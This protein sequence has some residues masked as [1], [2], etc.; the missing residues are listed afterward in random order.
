MRKLHQTLFLQALFLPALCF[1]Q[2]A[3]V[4]ETV[5]QKGHSRYVS[6]IAYSPDGKY[7]ASGSLDNTI[8]LWNAASNKI[9]R[10]F[11]SHTG[12]IRHVEFNRLGNQILS[13]AS[14]NK[15]IVHDI[16]NGKIIASV[17]QKKGRLFRACFSPDGSKILTDDEAND[18]SVWN[19]NTGRLIGKYSR[20]YSAK[21]EPN[22]F[23][24]DGNFLLI[25]N[26]RETAS[27]VSLE[28]GD[29]VRNFAIDK[30]FSF[31]ISGN[32][33]YVVIGSTKNKVKVFDLESGK[34][35]FENDIRKERG[36]DGCRAFISIGPKNK[37]I[38]VASAEAA[39]VFD[40]R[41]GKT[42]QY[43]ISKKSSIEGVGM[44]PNAQQ[45]YITDDDDVTIYSIASGKKLLDIDFN[46][47]ECNV[48]IPPNGKTMLTTHSN[49]R[50]ALWDIPK[51]KIVKVY[52]G[53]QNH[54]K[55]DGMKFKEG[56]WFHSS[57]IRY[58]RA[59]SKIAITSDGK[60]L[61]KGNVDTV[62]QM[63]NLETGRVERTFLGHSQRVLSIDISKDEK[64]LLTSSADRT[65]K[66][67]DIASGKLIK[68]IGRHGE[69]VFDAKF[70]NNNKLIASASWDGNLITWDVKTGDVVN[71]VDL[72][73]TSPY[74]VSFTPNDLYLVV[75]NLSKELNFY[76]TD[77][78]KEFRKLI[79]HS[80]I[81]SEV[82][83]STDNNRL[84]SASFDGKLKVW[85][86]LSGML[87]NK[88]EGHQSRVYSVA[89]HPGGKLIASG[90]NDRSIQLWD[91]NT[92][93]LKTV[94]PGHSG[95]VTSIKFDNNGKRLVSCSIEG[96]IKVWD[97]TSN[98]ELY[99][100]IPID[101]N[102]WLAKTPGGYFDGTPDALKHIN[103]VS[104][105]ETIPVGS[106]F[107]K[108]YSPNLIRRINNGEDFRAQGNI[109]SLMN[110]VPVIE[111]KIQGN[112]NLISENTDSIDWYSENATLNIQVTDQGG[113][114]DEI[115]IYNNNKLIQ[116]IAY[117]DNSK[118]AGRKQNENL[119]LA[120][121]PG[122]N[123]I[124]VIAL[125][126]ERTE[127]E[128]KSL[129][130][131]YDGL[132]SDVD[133]FL[134]TIGIDEYQNPAYKLNYAT[135]DAKAYTKRIKKSTSL[136]KSVDEVF[137]KD[138]NADKNTIKTA[139]NS[140]AEMAGPEDVFVFYFA[141]HGAM[142][143]SKKNNQEYF[144]IPFD[145]TNIYGNDDLLAQ[146]AISTTELMELSKRIKAR[147]QLFVL[148]ACQSGG[149]LES[150]KTR[151]ASR[152]KAIA[153]LARSSGTFF[154][155]ASG[156][157]QYASEARE[158]GHGIFTYAILEG[159]EGSADGSS[160]DAKITA[161]ELKSYVEDR[162]PELTAKYMLTPQYPTGYSF[163]Q[164]FPIVIVK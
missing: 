122:E 109:E 56:N 25:Y 19:A 6:S 102:N 160:G 112:E 1:G 140:I 26:N 83:F 119:E 114:I 110:K 73:K 133:L 91:I 67:W 45:I 136:F 66:L 46:D 89:A 155:L 12:A 135:N 23:S 138:N 76:E 127:S 3:K 30:P 94:L 80:E 132:E 13:C 157:I 50:M 145:V 18:L 32:N 142:G 131:Y 162:V 151:G 42:I 61:F 15:A 7:I 72:P 148:D 44:G 100:Y 37:Y 98:T 93:E 4:I 120:I 65:I 107:E 111:V 22:W 153:Q 34:E 77:V 141:G 113:G 11:T 17:S 103:Y 75:S 163:G 74:S 164:D 20:A 124:S 57:I 161:N 29:T 10:T 39:A 51:G 144:I 106:L 152:E 43:L 38:A 2:K 9:I 99:T 150:F 90:G 14:D 49:Q 118:R 55:N 104:G 31:A 28:T 115:R 84:I 52:S 92:G 116:N 48:A 59:K 68:T 78:V 126:K 81:V 35:L 95:G 36:C 21:I 97:L 82:C 101:R 123:K 24:P 156:A 69:V 125:D 85:D 47:Q 96:E 128:P 64:W 40:I 159:L 108:Y 16:S 58:I 143:S 146:K 41:S 86:L 54:Q 130:V 88:Y 62:A 139:F 105:L 117:T 8:I 71:Y 154:L 129:T 87:I 70:S 60:F 5:I 27:L 79:G 63:I 137:I 149:A 121:L 147:K 33:K 158:L 53:F 134:L